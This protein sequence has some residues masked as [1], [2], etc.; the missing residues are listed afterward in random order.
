MVGLSVEGLY[1]SPFGSKIVF[2]AMAKRFPPKNEKREF[3]TLRA[4][5]RV[6]HG[7]SGAEHV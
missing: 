5:S 1:S 4:E 2:G 6:D 3:S 7:S